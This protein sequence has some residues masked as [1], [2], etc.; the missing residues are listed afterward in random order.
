MSWARLVRCTMGLATTVLA[1]AVQANRSGMEAGGGQG[2]TG[3]WM[4]SSCA[5]EM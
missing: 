1:L 3:D 2:A 4:D 5:I